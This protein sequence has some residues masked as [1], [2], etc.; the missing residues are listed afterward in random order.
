M[1]WGWGS[2]VVVDVAPFIGLERNLKRQNNRGLVTGN[3][4]QLPEHVLNT[5][6]PM[7]EP[8]A[9]SSRHKAVWVVALVS[10]PRL[11]FQTTHQQ[12]QAQPKEVCLAEEH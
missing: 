1:Q 7:Y 6:F 11:I 12:S 2:P 4:G 9:H 3:Q 10:W 8:M 5:G